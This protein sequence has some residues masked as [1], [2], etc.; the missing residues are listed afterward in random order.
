MP[1]RVNR[2][3]FV[4]LRLSFTLAG[5]CIDSLLARDNGL[6]TPNP[7]EV[8]LPRTNLSTFSRLLPRRFLDAIT[9]NARFIQV[10][11]NGEPKP[12]PLV[13]VKRLSNVFIGWLNLL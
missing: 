7:K 8:V 1:K 3:P 10:P 11:V 4:R 6:F 12:G 2:S 13:T 5:S 9:R